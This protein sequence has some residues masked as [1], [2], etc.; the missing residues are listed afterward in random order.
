MNFFDLIPIAGILLSN[1]FG[2]NLI[3]TFTINRNGLDS[4]DYNEVLFPVLFINNINWF[5]Y[6]ILY[7][8]LYISLSCLCGTYGTFLTSILF[9]KYSKRE[10]L[11]NHVFS[12]ILETYNLLI[13][14]IIFI[15]FL[16][17]IISIIYLSI[18][19]NVNADIILAIVNNSTLFTHILTFTIPFYTLRKI[20]K[21]G[22]TESIY[23]P[24]TFIGL[25]NSLLWTIYGFNQ[26]NIY[27]IITNGYGIISSF[28][29]ILITIYYRRNLI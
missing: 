3:Y 5:I 2:L 18:F 26:N 1:I 20:I 19:I 13:I 22:N 6:G 11:N 24:F 10:I 21:L 16:T 14:E 4:R 7:H 8:D 25:V 23:T 15:V 12:C 28:I 27:Q 29:Q 17:Y 9:Y